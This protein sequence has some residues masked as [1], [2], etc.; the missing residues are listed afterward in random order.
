MRQ[1]PVTPLELKEI[2]RSEVRSLGISPKKCAS[3]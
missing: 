3:A 1:L 2:V